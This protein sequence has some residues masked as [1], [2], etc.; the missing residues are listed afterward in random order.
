MIANHKNRTLDELQRN[1]WLS[2][3]R[4]LKSQILDIKGHIYFEFAIPRMGKRA[5]NIIISETRYLLLNLKSEKMNIILSIKIR[6][7]IMF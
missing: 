4:I 7:L 3:I 2:Q 6:L 1:A 5:D